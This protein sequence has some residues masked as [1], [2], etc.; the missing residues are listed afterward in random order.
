[1]N[2]KTLAA[3]ILGAAAVAG[4]IY[5][6]SGQPESLPE[7]GICELHTVFGPC[8]QLALL[9]GA[10]HVPACEGTETVGA[11]LA[12]H[13]LPG[14][15]GPRLG[16]GWVRPPGLYRSPVD[17]G[18]YEWPEERVLVVPVAAMHPESVA[19]IV[20]RHA[21]GEGE[22]A[23]PEVPPAPGYCY[24]AGCYCAAEP[25]EH[26]AIGAVDPL[27]WRHRL[28]RLIPDAPDCPAPEDP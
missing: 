23:T 25:C 13:R 22:W 7:G 8:D 10:E 6:G 16:A 2:R 1:M 15:A 28:C 19:G 20:G 26:V 3:A 9:P 4:G 17:C 18:A 12:L 5:L 24:G 27:Y 21:T 14:D 11:V